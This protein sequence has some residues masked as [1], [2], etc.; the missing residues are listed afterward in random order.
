MITKNNKF[1]INIALPLICLGLPTLTFSGCSSGDT[2]WSV[3][4]QE[5][6]GSS[7]STETL[8]ES[9]TVLES[10]SNVNKIK[11]YKVSIGYSVGG[12]MYDVLVSD[13]FSEVDYENFAKEYNSMYKI[14]ATHLANLQSH[15]KAYEYSAEW[16]S[17][18]EVIKN[19]Y[20]TE[21]T[22]TLENLKQS[23][24]Y[25]YASSQV[26]ALES[27]TLP[28]SNTIMDSTERK[29]LITNLKSYLKTLGDVGY[30]PETVMTG[31]SY[32]ELIEYICSQNG[33]STGS[34]KTYFNTNMDLY[35]ALRAEQ[36][37]SASSTAS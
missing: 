20:E 30:L 5:Q 33:I 15:L 16:L 36:S 22:S 25:D 29:S 3:S 28:D 27:L 35:N 32:C 9:S 4:T 17:I 13:D 37:D 24:Y 23:T 19:Q 8:G 1:L 2:E 26:E 14:V 10:F 18:Y 12:E 31:E 6:L 21:I 34:Y 7:N 11:Q